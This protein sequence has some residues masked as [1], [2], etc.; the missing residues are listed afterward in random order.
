MNSLS[1]LPS[2]PLLS[3][4]FLILFTNLSLFFPRLSST[5]SLP[6]SHP[7]P[8]QFLSSWLQF[9]LS[10]YFFHPN[11]FYLVILLRI[12][13]IR[14]YRRRAVKQELINPQDMSPVLINPQD[15]ELSHQPQ[16]RISHHLTG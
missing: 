6:P 5:F 16:N 7:L 8:Q 13:C 12:S 11:S 10:T 4:L 1:F 14:R 2:L 3:I 9:N 15:N